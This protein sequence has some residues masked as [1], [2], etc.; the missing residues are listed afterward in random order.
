[1]SIKCYTIVL[2][3]LLSCHTKR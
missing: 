2:C 3:S 1:M